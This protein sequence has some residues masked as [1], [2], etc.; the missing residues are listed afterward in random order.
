MAQ[1]LHP[2]L[3]ADTLHFCLLRATPFDTADLPQ[4]QTCLETLSRTLRALAIPNLTITLRG[5]RNLRG[6]PLIPAQVS[7]DDD[8]STSSFYPQPLGL[9]R[10]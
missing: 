10:L 1:P 4:A 6:P 2:I 7:L 3:S 8:I 5:K 9:F